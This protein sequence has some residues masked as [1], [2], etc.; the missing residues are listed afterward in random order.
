MG[1]FISLLVKSK[2]KLESHTKQAVREAAKTYPA[3]AT[4]ARNG[5]LEP[6]QPS[7]AR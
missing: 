4:E 5:S 6:G 2:S 1:S 3:P 7:R